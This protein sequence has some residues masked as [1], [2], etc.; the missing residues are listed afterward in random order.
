MRFT[1]LLTVGHLGQVFILKVE[2]VINNKVW[3]PLVELRCTSFQV[4]HTGL[5]VI[6]NA[7]H[8]ASAVY[9]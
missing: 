8:D 7:K 6:Y 2:L 4:C 1:Y 9:V 3:D 5:P